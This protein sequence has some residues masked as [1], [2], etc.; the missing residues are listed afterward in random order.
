MLMSFVGSRFR[1]R[2]AKI[3]ECLTDAQMYWVA[4]IRTGDSMAVCYLG[5]TGAEDLPVVESSQPII[6][7][8]F[9]ANTRNQLVVIVYLVLDLGP[10]QELVSTRLV[11]PNR[12]TCGC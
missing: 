9:L 2:S 7:L 3:P 5:G 10:S 6:R 4:R 8:A 11:A 1:R 12:Q